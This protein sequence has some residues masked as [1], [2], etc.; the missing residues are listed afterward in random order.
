MTS[1][2]SHPSIRILISDGRYK[3][4][5]VALAP[6]TT[7]SAEIFRESESAGDPGCRSAA[8]ESE[9]STAPWNSNGLPVRK[10]SYP[11]QHAVH[12]NVKGLLQTRFTSDA[13]RPGRLSD[14]TTTSGEASRLS[15][16]TKG[17]VRNFDGSL[18]GT[19]PRGVSV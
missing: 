12:R 1:V 5:S 15:R 8:V 7:P 14:F 10:P 4:P 18:P 16:K 9:T 3:H 11:L 2:S 13:Q 6:K 17:E 19:A